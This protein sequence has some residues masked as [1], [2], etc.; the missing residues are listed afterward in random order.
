MFTARY[1]LGFRM[2][3]KFLFLSAVQWFRPSVADV[4]LRKLVFDPRSVH[5]GHRVDEM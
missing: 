5:V 4:S 2:S 3:G 1:G